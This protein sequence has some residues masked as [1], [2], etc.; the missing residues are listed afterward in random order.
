MEQK[1]NYSKVHYLS[2]TS[3]TFA[4]DRDRVLS[5]LLK[6][7]LTFSNDYTSS[8]LNETNK[9]NTPNEITENSEGEDQMNDIL[10]K[11]INRL[12]KEQSD[13]KEDLRESR[14]EYRAD[15][16]STEDRISQLIESG[17]KES[18]EN[19]RRLEDK[20]DKSIKES[21]E[22]N[23]RLADKI[24]SNTKYTKNMSITTIIG[25]AGMVLA[26]IALVV[27]VILQII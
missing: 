23:K 3:R 17:I 12:D 14:R 4:D 11:Y 9:D 13:L 20:I 8:S 21:T 27:T 22:D 16:K 25:I 5:T 15:L 18:Q 26:A 2:S 10:S 19:T 1:E 24:D 7:D 6:H